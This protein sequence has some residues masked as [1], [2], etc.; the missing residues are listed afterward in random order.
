MSITIITG[1]PG[2][3][4]TTV[5]ARLARSAPLAVHLVGD[6]VFHWI[7]SG[8]V[9]PWMPDTSRQNGTVIAAMANAAAE[10]SRSGYQVFVDGIIGPWFLPRWLAAAPDPT[11]YVILRPSG[12]V[13]LARATARN[14]PEDLVDPEPVAKVFEAFQG[15]DSFEAHIVD[16]SGQDVDTTVKAVAGGLREGRYLVTGDWRANVDRLQ[17]KF[18][19]DPATE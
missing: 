7:A 17:R 3:G 13:A 6:Q 1:P 16:S 2:A 5:A 10:F 8:Y 4:K 12:E 14:S 11:Q 19:I 18:G 15:L 9:P